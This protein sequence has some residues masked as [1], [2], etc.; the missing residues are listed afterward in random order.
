M[1]CDQGNIQ[2]GGAALLGVNTR[3]NLL[4]FVNTA[5]YIADIERPIKILDAAQTEALGLATKTKVT[6]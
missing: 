3:D 4:V 1:T 5:A 2:L 6:R